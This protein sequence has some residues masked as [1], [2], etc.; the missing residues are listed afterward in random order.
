MPEPITLLGFAGGTAAVGGILARRHFDIAKECVDIL[1][2]AIALVLVSPLI[3]VCA[4][5]IKVS[6]RGPVFYSQIRVGKHGHLFRLH[7]LRTM[8]MDAETTQGAVWAEKDDPRVLPACRWMRRCHVDELPQLLSV[9]TGVMSL[10]GPRPERPEIMDQLL[11]DYSDL[12]HQI[13]RRLEV[14]PGITGLAQLRNGYD[15][16]VEQFRAK[17][18]SDLE[19]IIKRTWRMELRIM[20]ATIT[21][22]IRDRKAH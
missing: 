13:G 1:L 21:K 12:I 5:L 16:S 15:T 11:G 19:Y 8:S 18:D 14:R 2:G 9:I 7:K 6:S 17:L 3:L 22:L 10:V 20:A 4:L